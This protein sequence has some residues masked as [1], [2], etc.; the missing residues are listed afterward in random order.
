MKVFTKK[1][2][3]GAIAIVLLGM[4]GSAGAVVNVQCPGDIGW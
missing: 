4:V 2:L 1:A 3:S